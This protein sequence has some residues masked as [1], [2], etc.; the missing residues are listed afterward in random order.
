MSRA[1]KGG[2][3]KL[4]QRVVQALAT[5]VRYGDATPLPAGTFAARRAA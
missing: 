2:G 5:L 1:F 3:K 4:E